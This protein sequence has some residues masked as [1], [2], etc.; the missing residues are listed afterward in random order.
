MHVVLRRR[1]DRGATL[2]LVAFLLVALLTIV[3]LVVDLSFVR[4]TRQ[5]SKADADFA[6]AAG[7][8]NM[9]N[10]SGA[11]QP[12][13]GICAA[14]DY[15]IA[16]NPTF[17]GMA[18]TY[19]GAGAT[20]NPCVTLPAVTCSNASPSY[21]VLTGVADAGRLTVEI[22]SAYALPDTANFP[23]DATYPVSDAG[24]GPC[25]NLAVIITA[26]DPAYFG[27]VA[28][29][30]GQKTSI[31]SVARLVQGT[32]D[33]STAALVL[34]ERFSCEAL[35]IGG[36]TTEGVWVR[37]FGESPGIIHADSIGSTGCNN[38]KIFHVN[39]SGSRQ[40]RAGRAESPVGA[41]APGLI[42][43]VSMSGAPGAVPANTSAPSPSQVCAQATVTDC[44]ATSPV[45]GGGA[46]GNG[47][48]GRGV[49]D[50][51]YR[52]PVLSRYATASQRFGMTL[53]TA[54]AAGFTTVRNGPDADLPCNTPSFT[55]T[56]L[57]IDC[58]NFGGARTFASSVKEV[59][60]RGNVSLSSSDVMRFDEPTNVYVQ[61][62]VSL[63]SSGQF[64]VNDNNAASCAVRYASV[65][66]ARAEL[67]IGGG[68]NLSGGTLRLC[69]TTLLLT[70]DDGSCP[71]PA[72]GAAPYSNSCDGSI[73]SSGQSTVDWSA[74]NVNNLTTPSPTE[75]SNL[76]DLALWTE[77]SGG[78]SLTGNGDLTMAGIFFTPN[79]D[80]FHIAG[81]GAK[82]TRDAQ[83]LTRKLSVAGNGLLEMR[84]DP[85]NAVQIPVLGGFSLAR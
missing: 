2:V 39:G 68:L 72:S 69:Q 76:E 28:G 65:P 35:S 9:D 43:A 40:I 45:T 41:E 33:A 66:S 14:R 30:S 80:P 62:N 51:R 82:N 84:P 34:L 64:R 17:A 29:S 23:E 13:R 4:D 18:E 60:I 63:S 75:L 6:V 61:G 81:N 24:D 46:T 10:G 36:A 47:L 16:N 73:S 7:I 19:A 77:T 31:R 79:A 83:F 59:V 20:A 15:L 3:A 1:S 85:V 58:N 74:P 57:W 37:G 55:A 25:D 44:T 56:R 52:T 70:D 11:V 38:S 71:I 48:V 42:T 26:K 49:V 54:D 27:G 12:W 21:A 78:H 5:T 50:D 8:R 67:V 22:K 32:S 53:E